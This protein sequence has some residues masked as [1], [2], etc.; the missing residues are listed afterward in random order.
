MLDKIK[1]FKSNTSLPTIYL[2]DD[3]LQKKRALNKTTMKLK[4][5]Y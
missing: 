2:V 1:F 3:Y 5:N 4:K